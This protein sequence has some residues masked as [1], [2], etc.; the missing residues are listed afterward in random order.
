MA[1]EIEKEEPQQE[2]LYAFY[3]TN[4]KTFLRKSG[5]PRYVRIFQSAK[6]AQSEYRYYARPGLK[7]VKLNIERM[8][9]FSEI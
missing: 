1:T 8:F 9:D 3:D 2:E 6:K 5:G 4:T 7:I